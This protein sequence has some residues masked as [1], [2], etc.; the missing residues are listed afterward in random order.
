MRSNPKA[1]VFVSSVMKGFED[2]RSAARRGIEAAGHKPVM[3]EDWRS[4]DTSSRNACLDQV[5]SADAL[6]VVVGQR[7]G[8]TAPSGKL[9]VEEEW[10]EARQRKMPVRVFVQ[11]GVEHDE[12]AVRL[13]RALSDYTT[14]YF[15]RSFTSAESLAEEVQHAL[16]ELE[17]EGISAEQMTNRRNTVRQRALR[18]E[19]S[20]GRSSHGRPRLRFVV[21][22]QRDSEVIDPRRMDEPSFQHFVMMS[23]SDPEIGLVRHGEPLAPHVHRESL[24]IG[25]VDER[26]RVV[27]TDSTVRITISESG[28]LVVDLALAEWG[29]QLAEDPDHWLRSFMIEASSVKRGLTSAFAFTG[30]VYDHVDPHFRFETF[31][32]DAVVFDSRGAQMVDALPM[33]QRS[34]RIAV[35]G[36]GGESA[37][38]LAMNEPR[39]ASRHDF[40]EPAEEV[41]RLCTRLRRELAG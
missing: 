34:H 37:P 35:G 33:G 18:R 16:A 2:M 13:S 6:I 31:W 4:Q 22:P 20:W 39:A 24:V 12:D 10:E 38:V 19:A 8:W 15:R 32:M 36:L 5:A 14:G 30:R 11:E 7:G 21:A 26:G 23:A 3:A 25:P 27:E 17:V 29:P 41:S 40:R 1:R 28:F 9:V